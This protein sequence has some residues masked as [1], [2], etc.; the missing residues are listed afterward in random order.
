VPLRYGSFSRAFSVPEGVTESDIKARYK[1]GILEVRI[2][3]PEAKPAKKI[4]VSN[5]Q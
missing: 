4:A 5:A 1:D 2:P 3:F